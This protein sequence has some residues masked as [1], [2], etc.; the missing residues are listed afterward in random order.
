[1]SPFS[2][3]YDVGG[4]AKCNAQSTGYPCGSYGKP[5]LNTNGTG[6]KSQI[7]TSRM[8]SLYHSQQHGECLFQ[9]DL[10]FPATLV[11]DFGAP[12]RTLLEVKVAKSGGVLH[13]TLR[14]FNKTST[15]RP[16]AMWLTMQPPAPANAVAPQIMLNKLGASC[17]GCDQ[18]S[19]IDAMSVVHNG[20]Q[21]VH[22]VSDLGIKIHRPGG[23]GSASFVS[24]DSALVRVGADELTPLPMPS[25]Q[26]NTSA[27]CAFNLWNNAWGECQR[28]PSSLASDLVHLTK[29]ITLTMTRV[30]RDELC[31]VVPV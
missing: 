26:P 28:C 19:W 1:M 16:E 22:A 18:G 30:R 7:V 24:R 15:R 20:S 31:D 9:I 13:S 5:G 23:A 25:T 8:T 21:R 17:D 12:A 10:A 14:M 3:F 4:A 29:T 2:Y 6:P 11:S 27:G